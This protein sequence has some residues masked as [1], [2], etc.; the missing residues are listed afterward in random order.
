MPS[1]SWGRRRTPSTHLG[2]SYDAPHYVED[3]GTPP[4]CVGAS[5]RCGVSYDTPH[6]DEHVTTPP[7]SW[8]IIAGHPQ[9]VWGRPV[10]A[11]LHQ[12]QESGTER[13]KLL[14]KISSF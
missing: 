1:T 9:L 10:L 11:A 12:H 2:A 3:V 14:E 4:T 6:Y 13:R 7:T 5:Y 8:G